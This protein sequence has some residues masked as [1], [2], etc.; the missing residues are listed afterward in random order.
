MLV[1]IDYNLW[2]WHSLHYT[3]C[4]FVFETN[5]IKNK[6]VPNDS[7]TSKAEDNNK[8]KKNINQLQNRPY[9]ILYIIVS[10]LSRHRLFT[11]VPTP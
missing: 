5:C 6:Q 3:L 10:L 1:V 2:E 4:L 7:H 9:C 11:T 8:L